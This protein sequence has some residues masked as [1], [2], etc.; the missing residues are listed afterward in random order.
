MGRFDNMEEYFQQL[1]R[2]AFFIIE[3]T[4]ALSSANLRDIAEIV[5]K[6]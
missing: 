6:I 4:H 2:T 5:N 3:L 1:F